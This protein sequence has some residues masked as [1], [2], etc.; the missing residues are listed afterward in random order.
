M[1]HS[2]TVAL[3]NNLVTA[4]SHKPSEAVALLAKRIIRKVEEIQ[5][6]ECAIVLLG[7]RCWMLDVGCPYL[8]IPVNLISIG[9]LLTGYFVAPRHIT[10]LTGQAK[11]RI[12]TFLGDYH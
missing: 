2:G 11:P 9:Q 1:W 6:V 5:V 10:L 12:P 8:R 3:R 4:C 7:V